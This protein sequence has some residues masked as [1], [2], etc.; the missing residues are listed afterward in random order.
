MT[1]KYK[2]SMTLSRMVMLGSN[3]KNKRQLVVLRK[4][5]PDDEGEFFFPELVAD[6]FVFAADQIKMSDVI[7]YHSNRITNAEGL[8]EILQN[9]LASIGRQSLTSYEN[10]NKEFNASVT[11]FENKMNNLT[12]KVEQYETEMSHKDRRIRELEERMD[13]QRDLFD[14]FVCQTGEQFERTIRRIDD[15]EK[16]REEVDRVRE[17]VDRVRKDVDTLSESIDRIWEKMRENE[18]RD[19]KTDEKL[20]DVEGTIRDILENI[21]EV[22]RVRKDLDE[23]SET[24][25]EIREEIRKK[26]ESIDRIW[27]KMRENEN[28]DD[29]TDKKLSDVEGTIRDIC[30]DIEEVQDAQEALK[31]GFTNEIK[32]AAKGISEVRNTVNKVDNKLDEDVTNLRSSVGDDLSE[33]RLTIETIKDKTE[34]CIRTIDTK[35]TPDL[36]SLTTD[37]KNWQEDYNKD[38]LRAE[39]NCTNRV[40]TLAANLV[41][42]INE[43]KS[44]VLEQKISGDD[45]KIVVN[46]M[47]E[48][49]TKMTKDFERLVEDESTI[50]VCK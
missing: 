27:E 14:E 1:D 39:R 10:V 43:I 8:L 44:N 9:N 21:E 5:T 35:L 15:A 7:K 3:D 24:L 48:N 17:E 42:D 32:L 19:D 40:D 31:N 2:P 6:D 47:S 22:D 37:F 16:M 41:H 28:R 13:K 11:S 26:S 30:G 36:V 25:R 29:K 45:L 20:S 33:V 23:H 49:F 34:S 18:N 12:Q 50:I 38:L 4:E 46:N